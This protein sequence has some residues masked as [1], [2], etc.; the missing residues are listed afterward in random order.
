VTLPAA[1]TATFRLE[2]HEARAW[3]AETPTLH[4][5]VL[6]L[7]TDGASEPVDR[8]TVRIGLREVSIDAGQ[9]RVNGRAIEIRGVN[10]H[11]F[12]PDWGR[13]V[14]EVS[15]ERDVQLMKR[16]NINAV[17]TAHYPTDH[18]FLDLC[19]R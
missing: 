18:R 1:G 13:S 17:R 11:E 5:L 3:T 8:R 14:D 15:M 2:V 10:R 7:G 4:D 16:H 19:D 12:E 9:L 6:E